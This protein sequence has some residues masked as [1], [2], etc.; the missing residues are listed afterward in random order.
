MGAE[1]AAKR[2]RR[3]DPAREAAT[4]AL[5]D[6]AI[7]FWPGAPIIAEAIDAGETFNGE[8]LTLGACLETKAST[9]ISKRVSS[10]KLYA[11]W[12]ETTGQPDYNFF[13]EPAIWRY[14][15]HL[16]SDKAPASRASAL[17]EAVNFFGGVFNVNVVPIHASSRLRGMA[18]KQLR[19][20]KAARQ[21]KPLSVQMVKALEQFLD[22]NSAEP[23]F[24]SVIAGAA[25]F[26]VYS[27]SRVG[28]LSRCATDPTVDVILAERRGYVETVF[29]EH[30]TAKPGTRRALPITAPAY[31]ILDTCWGQQWAAAREAFGLSAPTA[32]SLLPA[33]DKELQFLNVPFRTPEFAVAFRSLLMKLDF[34]PELLENIG[35]HSLK[36][37]A[38]SWCAKYGIDRESRRMLGYHATPGDKSMDAYARAP[39]SGPL[40]ELERV[41]A[42][43]RAGTFIPDATQSGIFVVAAAPDDPP[44]PSSPTCSSSSSS[45]PSAP[46]SPVSPGDDSDLDVADRKFVQNTSTGYVHAVS[47][48]G[49]KLE[50]GKDFPVK[51]AFIIDLALA[52][53]FCKKCF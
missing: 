16:H 24:E 10:L 19:T 27:R 25:L 42:A 37:T 9:T 7:R 12:H 17:R 44:A 13:T 2:A 36:A 6:L 29:L 47:L 18:V 49:V 43:I 21:R 38:L 33:L 48:D 53:H 4:S 14:L 28:D 46:T 20:K 45:V 23:V 39:L 32:G 3:D 41:V 22:K 1:Q 51:N 35:A 34:T 15:V 50:C 31:G 5:A 11:A 52:K 26:A 8:S 30:K 40:R